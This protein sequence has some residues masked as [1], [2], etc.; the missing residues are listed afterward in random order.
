[1][2]GKGTDMKTLCLYY[3][4]TNSTKK[5]MERLAELT[6]ADLAEYTDGKD[7]SGWLG[8]L[9]ACIASMKKTF[10]KVHIK[11]EPD[12]RTYDRVVIGMPVWAEAPSVVGRAFIRKYRKKLPDQVYYA[13]THM[14]KTEYTEKI[15]AM[16]RLLGRPSAGQV[17]LRTKDHDFLQDVEAFAKALQQADL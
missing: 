3:T 11:G 12:L 17:S 8:Y 1:M 16:D 15:K 13:V 2:E 6:G 5:A 7:R 9:G 10:P 14:A 4:R